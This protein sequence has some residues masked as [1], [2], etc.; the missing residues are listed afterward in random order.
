M[1]KPGQS[2]S[3]FHWHR[4]DRSKFSSSLKTPQATR[5]CLGEPD[6]LKPT[7]SPAP[8]ATTK[9]I[10]K[11]RLKRLSQLLHQSLHTRK[12]SVTEQE[13]YINCVLKL[14]LWALHTNVLILVFKT[15]ICC[16]RKA[17]RKQESRC[18][19]KQRNCPG[20]GRVQTTGVCAPTVR[21]EARSRRASLGQAQREDLSHML[22]D[23]KERLEDKENSFG[24]RTVNKYL[25]YRS[26]PTLNFVA[27]NRFCLYM[28]KRN[29]ASSLLGSWWDTLN[30]AAADTEAGAGGVHGCFEGLQVSL[31]HPTSPARPAAALGPKWKQQTST[32]KLTQS[33]WANW[34]Q[35]WPH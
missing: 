35:I 28:E 2:S 3:W 27:A 23:W 15:S 21:Q 14:P 32:V 30:Q 26:K 18:H 20:K 34:W 29:F 11:L 8:V 16:G 25:K 24:A 6:L 31:L 4:G 22:S 17:G 7:L 1:T 12:T 19:P 5:Q 9:L 10:C 33:C 13:N